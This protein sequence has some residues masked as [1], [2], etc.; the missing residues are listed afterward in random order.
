MDDGVS[1]VTERFEITTT[2]GETLEARWDS[3]EESRFMTVFCHPSSVDGG[4][5]MAPL[6]I[7]VTQQLVARGHAVL[8]FNFRG[9]GSSTGEYGGGEAELAD[10][11]AAVSVARDRSDAIGLAGW[12]FGAAVAM[13]WLIKNESEIPYA[14]IAPPAHLIDGKPPTG[15]QRIILGSRERVID[16]EALK[17]FAIG[18]GIDLVITPGDHFFHGRGKHIGDLV[19]EGLE[20]GEAG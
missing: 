18:N 4:S 3:P 14:G 7:A 12:S 9:V 1:A 5:L 16:P 20:A 11:D 6:M 10:V 8:R 17:A 19:G 2:D 15:P 13:N